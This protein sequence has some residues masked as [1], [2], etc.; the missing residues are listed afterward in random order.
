MRVDVDEPGSDEVPVGVDLAVPAPIDTTTAAA[1]DVRDHAVGHGHV[2]D[3]T[4]VA[5]AVHHDPVADHQLVLGH[6]SPLL[7][8]HDPDRDPNHDMVRTRR[9]PCLTG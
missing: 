5:G 2:A 1:T 7:P 4:F 8:D 9:D 3:E 6:G